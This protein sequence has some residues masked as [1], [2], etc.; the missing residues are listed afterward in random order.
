M[1]A[2]RSAVYGS[3]ADGQREVNPCGAVGRHRRR[4][5]EQRQRYF[6][7]GLAVERIESRCGEGVVVHLCAG[8]AVL[9]NKS[10]GGL[11]VN[12]GEN[13]GGVNLALVGG[14]EG[15]RGALGELSV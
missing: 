7:P 15:W 11:W 13:G 6:L 2:Y 3:A 4:H 9:E 10:C 14:P 5:I 12:L 8:A 1:A